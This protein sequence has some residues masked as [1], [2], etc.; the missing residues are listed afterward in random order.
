MKSPRYFWIRLLDQI[1][2]TIKIQ[3]KALKY[4]DKNSYNLYTD[5]Y[6]FKEMKKKHKIF[7]DQKER[8]SEFDAEY[9]TVTLTEILSDEPSM[10]ESVKRAFKRLTHRGSALDPDL[11]NF[12][13]KRLYWQRLTN[14]CHEKVLQEIRKSSNPD[15]ITNTN[16]PRPEAGPCED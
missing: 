8:I 4:L 14:E 13:R 15:D 6:K 16:K 2:D 7:G 3:Y 1:L 12:L 5:L 11:E 10:V 9:P